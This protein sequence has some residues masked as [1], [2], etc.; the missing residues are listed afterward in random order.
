[1]QLALVFSTWAS[2]VWAAAT[3]HGS[4]LAVHEKR[5]SL[6]NGWQKTHKLDNDFVI[7]MSIALKQ[8]NLDQLDEYI[9]SVSS[10]SSAEYGSHW[11]SKQVAEAFAPS[12]ET[13]ASV[14]NWLHAAGIPLDRVYRST[15]LGWLKFALTVKEAEE[16]LH[17]EYHM[18]EH[19]QTGVTQVGCKK[20]HV[21]HHV[22]RHVGK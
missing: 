15:S 9:M 13:A 8:S 12:E 21:P 3:L 22:R 2:S 4:G 19:V 1:M 10:P 11:T 7:P 5:D 17:T 14:L 20:Y 18:Y 16:L 6:P